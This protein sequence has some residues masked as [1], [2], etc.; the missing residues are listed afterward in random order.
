MCLDGNLLFGAEV[1]VWNHMSVTI[2]FVDF[3]LI[4]SNIWC[5]PQFVHVIREIHFPC[6]GKLKFNMKYLSV[7]LKRCY[8]LVILS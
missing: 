7:L 3:E 5:L 2:V 8:F 4:R 1:T 6:I